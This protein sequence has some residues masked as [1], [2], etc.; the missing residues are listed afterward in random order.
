MISIIV[1]N[2]NGRSFLPECID[3]V[4]CQ[5]VQDFE[6]IIVDNGSRDGSAEL[7]SHKYPKIELVELSENLG[8]TGGNIE[9]FKRASGQYIVL[10]NNDAVLKKNWLEVMIHAINQRDD[11][12]ICASKI[13]IDGTELLD[14]AGDVFTTAFNGTKRGAFSR[15]DDFDESGFVPG[16]CAA[17]VIYRRSMLDEIGF[18][19]DDFFLDHEDTDLSMRAWLAG[20]KCLYVPEAIAYHKVSSTQGNESDLSIYYFAR[21][22]LWVYVKNVPGILFI[23]K[24]P[25]RIFYELC[26]FGYFCLLRKKWR[27]FLRGKWHSILGL[28][29][30]FYKRRQIQNLVK[31][32]QKEILKSLMPVN[33]Y[34]RDRLN[35]VDDHIK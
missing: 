21:N 24:I 27:P 1:V 32:D 25:Q 33:Q 3:S 16:A 7:I 8:F 11:I 9:G 6:L 13:I 31:L 35:S 5:T 20:W 30:M 22:S 19:D 34:I 12:G 2:Y 23:K 26:S 4:L 10:L 29:K 14:C 28:P 18:L 15:H 17:A